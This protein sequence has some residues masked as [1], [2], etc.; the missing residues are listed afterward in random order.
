MEVFP[1]L[2]VM[3]HDFSVFTPT[4]SNHILF[5][6]GTFPI[7]SNTLSYQMLCSFSPS[8]TMSLHAESAL[9]GLEFNSTVTHFLVK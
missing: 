4:S 8:L 9:I 3:I 5:I 1:Y 7:A 6:S 2:F